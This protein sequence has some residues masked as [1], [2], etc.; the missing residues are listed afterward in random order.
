MAGGEVTDSCMGGGVG[1][2]GGVVCTLLFLSLA[3]PAVLG[4]RMNWCVSPLFLVGRLAGFWRGGGKDEDAVTGGLGGAAP[5]S[6]ICRSCFFPRRLNL[7]KM[8]KSV[9][10][11]SHKNKWNLGYS[12]IEFYCQLKYHT[13]S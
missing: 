10:I 12:L 2:A 11:V 5:C 3:V 7:N 6:R 8:N 1:T 13:F 4:G 9:L